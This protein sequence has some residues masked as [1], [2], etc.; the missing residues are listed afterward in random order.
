MENPSLN[1]Y[2][3]CLA[4]KYLNLILWALSF[5]LHWRVD[6]HERASSHHGLW[7]FVWALAFIFLRVITRSWASSF[8]APKL[9][10]NL[11]KRS[12]SKIYVQMRKRPIIGPR[13]GRLVILILNSC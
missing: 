4:P 12:T 8:H 7:S 9:V 11:Q 1:L 10:K 3:P 5:G 13:L 6:V 2:L